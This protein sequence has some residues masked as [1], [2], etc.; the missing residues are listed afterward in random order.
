MPIMIIISHLDH[1]TPLLHGLRCRHRRRPREQR[2]QRCACI[3]FLFFP[4]LLTLMW[5]QVGG[6]KPPVMWQPWEGSTPSQFIFDGFQHKQGGVVSSSTYF[7]RECGPSFPISTC[8][9]PL[10]PFTSISTQGGGATPP[11]PLFT[12]VLGGMTSLTAVYLHSR[13]GDLLSPPFTSVSTQG[14]GVTSSPHCS[15]PSQHREVG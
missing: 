4:F 13:W 6:L 8:S 3:I 15:P 9:S 11:S 12:S 2:V 5:Q 7:R 1:D 14:D 10:P